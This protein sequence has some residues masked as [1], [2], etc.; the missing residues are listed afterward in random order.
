MIFLEGKRCQLWSIPFKKCY[1]AYHREDTDCTED[2][3]LNF[4]KL[5]KNCY[6][7]SSFTWH[8]EWYKDGL[9]WLN[10]KVWDTYKSSG[11]HCDRDWS[12]KVF[13]FFQFYDFS[14]ILDCSTFIMIEKQQ[15]TTV[16]R[17]FQ[18]CKIRDIFHLLWGW[19]NN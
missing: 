3:F 8:I 10:G 6:V 1:S 16:S 11:S 19:A 4:T 13:N 17:L 18:T 7:P 9:L 2:I 12:T 5:A 14:N 15:F